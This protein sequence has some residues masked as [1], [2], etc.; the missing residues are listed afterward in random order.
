MSGRT[1]SHQLHGVGNVVLDEAHQ[2]GALEGSAEDGGEQCPPALGAVVTHD[3]VQEP[4]GAAMHRERSLHTVSEGET[5][6]WSF[7]SP[8]MVPIILEC[9]YCHFRIDLLFFNL[10]GKTWGK[11]IFI[12]LEKK[13]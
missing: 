8:C 9:L 5:I 1:S 12:Q 6:S 13:H 11:K 2:V 7:I 3:V 4:G 10:L